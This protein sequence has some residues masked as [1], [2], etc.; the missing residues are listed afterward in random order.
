MKTLTLKVP[1]ELYDDVKRA[2]E[3]MHVT[4][5][6]HVRNKLKSKIIES[7]TTHR[8]VLLTKYVDA[9]MAKKVVLPTVI[10]TGFSHMFI[11]FHNSLNGYEH[12]KKFLSMIGENIDVE[13]QFLD[14]C[15]NICSSWILVAEPIKISFT[16]LDYEKRDNFVTTIEFKVHKFEMS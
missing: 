14:A 3:L 11:E 4:V 13:L 7:R 6:E 10:S 16:D 5:S 15:G 12:N 9:F 1:D 8:W 2:A